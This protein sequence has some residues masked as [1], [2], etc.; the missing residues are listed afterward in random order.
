ME[1]NPL[2]FDQVMHLEIKPHVHLWV[3][4]QASCIERIGKYLVKGQIPSPR[5]SLVCQ[6]HYQRFRRPFLKFHL[7][8]TRPHPLDVAGER[9]CQQ[10]LAC[11]VKLQLAGDLGSFH[12]CV[13]SQFVDCG[14]IGALVMGKDKHQVIPYM[15]YQVVNE[16]RFLL[17]G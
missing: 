3:D 15:G 1:H 14:A 2:V 13:P 11:A 8:D 5:L 17:A 16:E 12:K 6:E 10:V 7:R 4:N 9:I